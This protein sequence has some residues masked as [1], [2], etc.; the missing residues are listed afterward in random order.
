MDDRDEPTYAEG[1]GPVGSGGA[2]AAGAGAADT[3]GGSGPRAI[4]HEPTGVEAVDR[5]LADVTS[6]VDAPVGDHVA[7][8]E[9]AHE[10]LRRALDARPDAARPGSGADR[11]A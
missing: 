4:D 2:A 6:V 8:F 11:D 1:A 5:V 3:V 10:E 9:R 7:V